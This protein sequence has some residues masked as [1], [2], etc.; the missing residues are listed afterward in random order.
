MLTIQQVLALDPSGTTYTFVE[1]GSLKP[2]HIAS[3]VLVEAWKRTGHKYLPV[4]EAEIG[5]TL[6]KALERGDLGVEEAHALTLPDE[7]LKAPVFV[8]VWGDT[9]IIIDGAHRL[10]RHWK[11]GAQGFPC[12]VIPEGLWRKFVIEG[13]PGDGAFW[14]TFNRTAQV[15]TPEMEL[16][17]KLLMGEL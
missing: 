15:R 9:H 10:W 13:M 17:R 5:G 12:V 7:A 3:G 14:D 1:Q 2:T 6:V 16:L 8:G 4:I 11:A